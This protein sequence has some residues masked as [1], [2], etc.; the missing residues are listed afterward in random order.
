MANAKTIHAMKAARRGELVKAG[1]PDELLASLRADR[2]TTLNV[3]PGT[4]AE[5]EA[6]LNARPRPNKRLRRTMKSRAPWE[7][8]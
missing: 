1:A 5:F 8:L 4:F 2:Q 3:T 7:R 6:R